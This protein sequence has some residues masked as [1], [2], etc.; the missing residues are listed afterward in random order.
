MSG[1]R[2]STFYYR[3]LMNFHILYDTKLISC[4]KTTVTTTSIHPGMSLIAPSF[5]KRFNV[6]VASTFC[7]VG[8]IDYHLS[9]SL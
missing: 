7:A 5:D 9:V 1:L 3:M 8:G 2:V 4:M 6:E